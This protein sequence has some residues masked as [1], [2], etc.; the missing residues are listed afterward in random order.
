MGIS[1]EKGQKISPKKQSGESLSQV[2]MG[3]GWDAKK[4]KGLFGGLKDGPSIDLD[5]SCVKPH[6]YTIDV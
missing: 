2:I 3:L 5:A 4:V 1:L 6:L